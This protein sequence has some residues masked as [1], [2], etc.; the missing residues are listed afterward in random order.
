[1]MKNIASERWKMDDENYSKMM[2]DE[3]WWFDL[4][5]NENLMTNDKLKDLIYYTVNNKN[6]HQYISV[7]S[8]IFFDHISLIMIFHCCWLWLWVC[9]MIHI[10]WFDLWKDISIRIKWWEQWFVT[11]IHGFIIIVQLYSQ[12][13]HNITH[14]HGW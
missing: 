2:E 3:W 10:C 8:H 7:L 14:V 6:I 9:T 12:Y 11:S 4:S 13:P 5:W 1:M